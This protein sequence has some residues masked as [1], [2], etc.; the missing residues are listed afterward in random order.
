MRPIN[1]LKTWV[2][3]AIGPVLTKQ[4]VNAGWQARIRKIGGVIAAG[5]DPW[6]QITS[7]MSHAI[8]ILRT[9][10]TRPSSPL[11]WH[12]PHTNGS[13]TV[14]NMAC[15]LDGAVNIT[16]VEESLADA[17][18]ANISPH[19]ASGGLENGEPDLEVPKSHQ[20]IDA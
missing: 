13:R 10:A 8:L 9:L 17:M 3:H 16:G 20:G 12:E 14:M 7:A 4:E 1:T 6:I 11:E 15:P 18:W 2:R 5:I 19:E